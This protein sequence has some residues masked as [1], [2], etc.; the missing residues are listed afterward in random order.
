[1]VVGR[2]RLHKCRHEQ[3]NELPVNDLSAFEVGHFDLGPPQVVHVPNTATVSSKAPTIGVKV[4]GNQGVASVPLYY[5]MAGQGEYAQSMM[6][7][8]RGINTYT[9]TLD[10]AVEPYILQRGG[11]DA[12]RNALHR[13]YATKRLCV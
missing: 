2:V 8:A 4:E 13:R 9:A 5:R 3:L 7:K 11:I 10:S 12:K 1:M 6:S